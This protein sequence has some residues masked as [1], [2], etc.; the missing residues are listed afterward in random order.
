MSGMRRKPVT[1]CPDQVVP[2]G[3]TSVIKASE[4]APRGSWVGLCQ[5][6]AAASRGLR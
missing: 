6:L 5:V 4:A 3:R 1:G 2:H